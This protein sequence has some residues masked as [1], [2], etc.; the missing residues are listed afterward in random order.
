MP[1]APATR[2][3]SE[4]QLDV[5]ASASSGWSVWIHLNVQPLD[6]EIEAYFSIAGPIAVTVAA[7][8]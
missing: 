7:A 3:R 1:V 5:R 4:L 6:A 8:R 2:T